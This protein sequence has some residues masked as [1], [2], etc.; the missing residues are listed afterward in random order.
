MPIYLL[1]FFSRIFN[2]K[3]LIVFLLL[4][5]LGVVIYI[6]F[7]NIN[8]KSGYIFDKAKKT[9]L[10]EIVSE[11]G[12]IGSDGNVIIYSPTN[13]SLSEIYVK[14]G[15][16]VKKDQSLFK[17]ESSATELEKQTAYTN[18]L[19]ASAALDADN[20]A[21]YSLQ[22]VMFSAWKIYTDLS[23]NSTYENS[24]KTPN[25]KNRILP[26]FTTAQDNW[27]AAEANYKNQQG[28][29]AKDQAALSSAFIA[30]QQTQTAVVR[31]PLD[32]IVENIAFSPGNS[33]HAQSALNPSPKPVLVIKNSNELEAVIPVGQTNIAKVQV[34]QDV[35]IKPDAYKDKTY[36]GT[37]VR[38]DDIGENS[39]GV[40]TYNIYVSIEK[41][42]LLR[43]GMTFDA[44][45][46]TKKLENV[47]A[48]PNSA[49][50]LDQGIKTVRIFEN[51]KVKFV[52]VGVGIKGETQTQILTGLSDG[53]EIITALT[54]ERAQ[55]P[56]F[57]GL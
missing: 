14:N 13:G 53:Q 54:N 46:T 50:V 29:I 11:S 28:I 40:V 32:G 49:V 30:Y 15:E 39:A 31:A 57:L 27:L 7:Q 56:G 26:E 19:A 22:S 35:L 9:S 18:Y 41:D 47:L 45:I 24:D 23:T 43:P 38:V 20:A 17:V 25:T 16:I 33:V 6:V 37:V 12:T 21:L 55:K 1:N 42:G 10:T 44:D 4:I 2:K 52:P 5:A 8:K 3:K 36:K 51:N 34:G 48:V